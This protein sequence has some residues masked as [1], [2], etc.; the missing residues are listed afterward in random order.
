[1]TASLP[2]YPFPEWRGATETLWASVRRQVPDL[3]ELAPWDADV[4]V[5]ALWRST[6]MVLS[7]ACGW[8]LVT[9]LAD[10]VRV[11][12]AFRYSTPRWSGDRYRS[13]IV[14]PR[15]ADAPCSGTA[16][17]NSH[18]SLSGW[19]SLVA[20]LSGEPDLA[21]ATGSH[22]ASLTAVA[23]GTAAFASVDAVTFAYAERH[24]PDLVAGLTVVG[25][26][27]CVPCLPLITRA[28]AT[29]ERVATL[30]HALAT[31]VREE[32]G[33]AVTLLIDGFSPLDD[34][35]YRA[36][37]APWVSDPAPPGR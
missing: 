13:V 20:F 9:A 25:E 14:A 12:G 23:D 8:P 26:G 6:S 36:A 4:D 27:P 31:A 32:T 15:G 28:D 33:S 37:L 16:A 5:H 18:D 21:I 2:M 7:Q 22:L 17:V 1:V 19:V 29:D 3:P 34:A 11:V 10:R 24:R 30:R 35:D